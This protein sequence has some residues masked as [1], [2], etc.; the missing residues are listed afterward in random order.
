MYFTLC[1]CARWFQMPWGQFY[2]IGFALHLN[3]PNCHLKLWDLLIKY[4]IYLW[5]ITVNLLI[6][7]HW[8]IL[9][10]D[11]C[12]EYGLIYLICTESI[13]YIYYTVC[14]WE[15]YCMCFCQFYF[16]LCSRK[17]PKLLV[18]CT[19]ARVCALKVLFCFSFFLF[20]NKRGLC[21]LDSLCRLMQTS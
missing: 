2:K 17:K 9:P 3:P 16:C 11:T 6:F 15:T 18:L 14:S 19:H 1:S 4:L 13:Q 5:S 7:K 21:A 20:F 12:F 8:K 10:S